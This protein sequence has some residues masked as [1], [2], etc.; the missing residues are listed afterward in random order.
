MVQTLRVKLYT[1]HAG[2]IPFHR[3]TARFR[4]VNCGRRWGKTTSA[5]NEESKFALDHPGV[6]CWWVAPIYRQA[7]IAYRLMKNALKDVIEKSSDT[8][9]RLELINGSIIECRTCDNPDNLRGDGVHFMVVEE[10]AMIGDKDVWFKVL[11]PMLS[12]TNG[13]AVFISTPKGRNWFYVLYCRG[14]DPLQKDYESFTFPTSSNPHIPADEIR[15]AKEDLPEDVFRQE[16]LAEFLEESAGVFRRV[17]SC[18]AGELED[19][20]PGIPYVLG[21]DP[22]KYN[23]FSVCSVLNTH[24]MHV[25]A[26]DR[27]NGVDYTVQLDRVY[28]LATQYN[29]AFV[30]MDCTGVGDP[31]LEQLKQK[32]LTADGYLL[33]NTSKKNLIEELVVAI[34]H[35]SIWYP[36]LPILTNELKIMEYS[37]TPSRNVQYSAPS[38]AH[39]DAVISLALAGHAAGQGGV[40]S[41]AASSSGKPGITLPPRYE[42]D[43]PTIQR[44]Q[45]QTGRFLQNVHLSGTFGGH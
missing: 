1:P 6:L 34:E 9:L 43:D 28:D 26:W 17:D 31:L 2:Q 7:K 18:I 21:W 30:L 19:P 44:R 11:R 24:T 40:I 39:D 3:S 25:D 23:D 41:F 33:N 4:V 27:F 29:S 35:Q 5:A 8:D 22:A 14:L 15:Q 42:T 36:D 32:G 16:Y 37:L 13:K 10:A 12:D 45:E 20:I 38:G